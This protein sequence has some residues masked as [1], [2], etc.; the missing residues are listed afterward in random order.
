MDI[1]QLN[2]FDG[3]VCCRCKETKERIHF[4]ADKSQ[5]DGLQRR[6][7]DCQKDSYQSWKSRLCPAIEISG[8]VCTRC[9]QWSPRAAFGKNPTRKDGMQAYCTQC[10]SAYSKTKAE[11]ISR[12]RLYWD[13]PEYYRLRKR[14]DHAAH[15]AERNQKRLAYRAAHLD[16]EKERIRRW[17]AANPDRVRRIARVTAHRRRAW[18]LGRPGSHTAKQWDG[19]L[20]WFGSACLCCGSVDDIQMDHVHPLSRGGSDDISNL[21]PLCKVCNKTK[22]TKHTDYRDPER[23][24]A[25][26]EH[27]QCLEPTETYQPLSP[28]IP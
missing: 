25:F 11:V 23:L 4:G 3:K 26:L 7:K 24:A 15:R 19:L 18:K 1:L 13:R 14:E 28:D 17:F 20:A 5:K 22:F 6:C 12:K 21:Q 9:G 16:T 8:K 2:M 27:I 10:R